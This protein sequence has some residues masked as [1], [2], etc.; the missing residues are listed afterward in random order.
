MCACA[1]IN[2]LG[3]GV[4]DYTSLKPLRYLRVCKDGRPKSFPKAK[5]S[6]AGYHLST[7]R[8]NGGTATAA[9]CTV[10]DV[11]LWC[12]HASLFE[13]K[14]LIYTS[15]KWKLFFSDKGLNVTRHLSVHK[16]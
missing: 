16:R 6:V 13:T 4:H 1:I 3:H 14:A 12:C 8:R 7:D 9:A 5:D 2:I 10:T 11:S 15:V